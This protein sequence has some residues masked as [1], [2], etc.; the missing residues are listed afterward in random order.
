MVEPVW[1][2]EQA[3]LALRLLEVAAWVT[4][5]PDPDGVLRRAAEGLYGVLSAHSAV[6][7]LYHPRERAL[8]LRAAVGAAPRVRPYVPI[9]TQGI[10]SRL[11]RALGPLVVPDCSQDP[12]VKAE[13]LAAGVRAFVGLPLLRDRLVRAVVYVNFARP[14][15]F[16]PEV[17]ALLGAFARQASAALDRAEAHRALRV[18]RDRMILSLAE[19][20]DARDHP[21]GG[22]SRRIQAVAR[23]VG[24]A[25]GLGRDQ[26][27][28]LETA[29]L[30]HDIGKIGVRDAVLLKP[31]RLSREE[32]REVEQHSLIG[33]R[34]L[35]AAGLSEEVVE[36]VRHAHEWYDGSGYPAGL[37]GEQ[38]P[39]LAR[40]VAVADAFEAMTADRPYRRGTTWEHALAELER[41]AGR[42]FDPQVVDALR[43]VLSD[44]R[45]RAELSAELSAASAPGLDPTA[46]LHPAEA[47]QL[48]AKSFYA[49]A[50]SFLEGFEQTAGSH[51]AQRLLDQLPVIPL[52]EP[53]ARKDGAV[54]VSSVT[55]RKRVH[56]YRAQLQ[57]MLSEAQAVCG[58]RICRNLLHDA[59]RVLPEGLQQACAFLLR[60]VVPEPQ[61][62]NG[63]S[64]SP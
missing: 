14:Q 57:K 45:S 16:P 54:A 22:H 9:R 53:S 23:A 28:S 39:L 41:Q 12:S 49:L 18:T 26:L 34:I 37:S 48:L 8:E 50:W 10:T 64:P 31:G 1:Q 42:Q 43:S 61:D 62:R 35:A 30:L 15:E 5:T 59:I 51:V 6:A 20:V 60:G 44:P 27:E 21:T 52:F 32:R 55:V 63:T 46:D 19:A 3:S 13:L 7:Y 2:G 33:A 29:A 25:L 11:L 56:Q 17:L 4:D 47:S 36:A 58:E 24:Q 40:I 38:I